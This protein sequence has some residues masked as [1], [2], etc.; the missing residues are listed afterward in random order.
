MSAQLV[1]VCVCT[2]YVASKCSKWDYANWHHYKVM[3]SHLSW[4]LDHNPFLHLHSALFPIS[5]GTCRKH[6]SFFY[7]T[8]T[9]TVC[10]HMHMLAHILS[11]NWS[12]VYI[13]QTAGLG[14]PFWISFFTHIVLKL[15]MW[16]ITKDPNWLTGYCIQDCAVNNPL[17][18]GFNTEIIYTYNLLASLIKISR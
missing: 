13:G 12:S 6:L 14:L 16:L 10:M 18:A 2:C 8:P 11:V 4:A 17:H 15:I 3:H 7:H 1:Y 9:Y 5:P